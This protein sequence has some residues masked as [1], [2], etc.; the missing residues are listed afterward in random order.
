[1]SNTEIAHVQEILRRIQEALDFI[2]KY[3]DY[4]TDPESDIGEQIPNEACAVYADLESAALRGEI[5]LREWRRA[6]VRET[7]QR[8]SR[9][10]NAAEDPEY[11]DIK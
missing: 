11:D 5:L 8:L 2:D 10:Y 9:R 4:H 1:M 6:Q 3:R 7:E